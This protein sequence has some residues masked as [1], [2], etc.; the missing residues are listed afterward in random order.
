[1]VD[2]RKSNIFDA[3]TVVG[4]LIGLANYDENITQSDL[5]DMMKCMLKNVHEHLEEQDNKIDNILELL[6]EGK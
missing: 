6:K 2:N 5:Q 3:M 1:M 4:F